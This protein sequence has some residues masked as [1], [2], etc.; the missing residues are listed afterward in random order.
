MVPPQEEEQRDVFW[1]EA[2]SPLETCK[3]LH[4]DKKRQR[5]WS[6]ASGR[7]DT[8]TKNVTTAQRRPKG[9]PMRHGKAPQQG[10]KECTKGLAGISGG[11]KASR[12]P[13][14]LG[15]DG[16]QADIAGSEKIRFLRIQGWG[17]KGKARIQGE[18]GVSNSQV[19]IPEGGNQ[20]HFIFAMEKRS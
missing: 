12:N 4:R 17:K 14:F 3:N 13:V 8:G 10:K 16:P 15:M 20:S 19:L 18:D 9:K 5:P 2:W 7:Q 11:T 1:G 6:I